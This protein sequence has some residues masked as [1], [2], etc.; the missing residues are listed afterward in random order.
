MMKLL[1]GV[2]KFQKNVYPKHKKLFEDLAGG[3]SP[4]V[5]FI[6][7]SDSRIDPSLITQAKPGDLFIIRNAGNIVPPH[8]RDAGGV[9]AS[10]EFAI[11]ALGIQHIVVCGHS[12]CGAMNGAMNP[13]GLKALPHVSQWL[14]YAE[15]A[16]HIVR[17]RDHASDE[18]RIADMTRENVLLQLQHLRTH[19]YVAAGLAAGRIELHGWIYDIESG[20][21]FSYNPESG[22]F[23]SVSDAH[24][25]AGFRILG[26]KDATHA[27][28]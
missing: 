19:P 16:A 3:Q 5:L 13:E 18:E 27:H 10:I 23:E 17:E 24:A 4:E 11:G 26:E 28:D 6:T 2:A 25:A 21:I 14:S 20:A 7:C 9:T 15:A 8:V 22:T 1:D 12:N